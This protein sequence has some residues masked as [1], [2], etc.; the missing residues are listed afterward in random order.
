MAIETGTNRVVAYAIRRAALATKATVEDALRDL[1]LTMLQYGTLCALR[2]QDRLSNAE[3]ARRHHV[4]PQTMNPI[5]VHL[6]DAGL[7]E[8]APLPGHGP[9]LAAQITGWRCSM[10]RTGGW[11]SST[12][13]WSL[14][15]PQRSATGSSPRWRPVSPHSKA[16]DR[17]WNWVAASPDLRGIAGMPLRCVAALRRGRD[18]HYAGVES[19]FQVRYA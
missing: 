8:R 1:N 16:M 12:S 14:R 6:E 3:L 2:A 5:V 11:R 13:A 4:T 18:P 19:E 7:I 17:A 9:I 10:K 15:S